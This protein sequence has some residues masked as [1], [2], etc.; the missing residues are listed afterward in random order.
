MMKQVDSGV[1]W[2]HVKEEPV[3]L[4][5]RQTEATRDTGANSSSR[6]DLREMESM[7]VA[8]DSR[9]WDVPAPQKCRQL[10]AS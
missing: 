5:H 10:R 7:G 9:F 8:V 3:F 2:G 6:L 4:S 1:E